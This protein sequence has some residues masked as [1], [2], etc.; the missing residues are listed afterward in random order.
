[1]GSVLVVIDSSAPPPSRSNLELLTLARRIGE[2]YAL[3]FG[4][5][6]DALLA[7]LA[8]HGAAGVFLVDDP[9]TEE[10][11][12][13][14]KAEAAAAAAAE[15]ATRGAVTAVLLTSTPE[16]KEIAG[17]L[18][19]KI[20][21]GIVTDA[22]DL[23]PADEGG[24]LVTQSAF[25]ATFSVDSTV[26]RPVVVTVKPNVVEPE[27]APVPPVGIPLAVRFSDVARGARI[28]AVREKAKSSR[29]GLVEASIVVSGGRGL[30]GPEKFALI[31]RLADQLGGAVGASRA[32]V[33]AGWYPHSNQ[34]GQTGTQVSPQL[35]VAIGISGAIQ[36]R[37]G[38]Q[39]S[40]TV[41]VVNKDPDAPMFDL[42][43]FGVVGDLNDV[44][45]QLSDCLDERV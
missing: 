22:I 10:Y 9:A 16:G 14:P 39:T 30:G 15:L 7:E 5:H 44:V 33:D 41:V 21:A 38:M 17:R 1:M 3:V 42:A 2:P 19:I 6:A 28:T 20:A 29:P 32:A 31:E 12:V 13:V 34:V 23:R 25:A 24:V 45:P 26:L 11:L 36:H 4:R 37:A 35:Y 27:A 18:A 43:D 40:R 8:D